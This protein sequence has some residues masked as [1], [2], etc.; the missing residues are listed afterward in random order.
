[1]PHISGGSLVARLLT[2]PAFVAGSSVPSLADMYIFARRPWRSQMIA[3]DSSKAAPLRAAHQCMRNPFKR[4]Q[5]VPEVSTTFGAASALLAS[6]L[7]GLSST[8]IN[9]SPSEGRRF[10]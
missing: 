1:M 4:V 3:S 8:R 10:E 7:T 2:S 9:A 5:E 6:V